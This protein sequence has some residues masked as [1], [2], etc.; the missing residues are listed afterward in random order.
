MTTISKSD[1]WKQI[2]AINNPAKFLWSTPKNVM[3][4]FLEKY[5]KDAQRMQ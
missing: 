1:L 5:N 4:E 3:L 2:K